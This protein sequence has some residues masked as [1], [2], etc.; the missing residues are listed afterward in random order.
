MLFRCTALVLLA[1]FLPSTAAAPRAARPQGDGA[2][3]AMRR[4]PTAFVENR[5]QTD[6]NVR[7][8]AQRGGLTAFFRDDGFVVRTLTF[9]AP[10]SDPFTPGLRP[11]DRLTGSVLAFRFEGASPA[12]RVEGAEPLAT[13]TSYLLGSDRSRW[14]RS[15]PSFASAIYRGV[16]PGV[17]VVF[18]DAGDHLEYDVNVAPG[19]REDQVAIAFEGALGASVRADGALAIQTALGEQIHKRPVAWE[20]TAS[21]ARHDVPCEIRLLGDGRF[22]FSVPAHDRSRALVIDPGVTYATFLPGSASDAGLSIA[23][24]DV[25]GEAYVTGW[26]VSTNFPATVGAF[27]QTANG[28]LDSYVLKLNPAGSGVVYATYLGGA[29]LDQGV[30]I[31]I[32]G[33]G[34]AYVVGNTLSIDF[35][36]TPGCFDNLWNFGT[37]FG[38]AYLTKLT[39][40]G[41]DL[42]YSTF[43]GGNGEEIALRVAVDVLGQAH[44]VGWTRSPD[45]P[46]SP[47]AVGTFD[48]TYNGAGTS[49]EG[50]AF[51]TKFNSTGSALLYST[52]LGGSDSDSAGGVAIDLAGK[53]YVVGIAR[54]GFPV[55]GAAGTFG[56]VYGGSGDAFITKID[57]TLTGGASVLYSKLLGSVGV[58]YSFGVAVDGSDSAYLTGFTGSPAFPTT[59][60]AFDKT[61]NG[62]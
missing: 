25:T 2:L 6:A 32:D 39:P 54:M 17:D 12:A 46:T 30:G 56:T 45:F 58:D 21:G 15:A 37:Q 57:T 52:F 48:A 31:A 28:N 42:D 18:R 22:G 59:V 14:V 62:G 7:L 34:S 33:S 41:D 4:L 40:A 13:R 29:A 38:D 5:G 50:D 61:Y 51:L 44:V 35:P 20:I 10:S 43:L 60:A 3:S 16:Y 36:V 11:N 9:P 26:T 24:D 23:V 47:P 19:A 27:D 53:T 49:T 55:T 8:V 1:S